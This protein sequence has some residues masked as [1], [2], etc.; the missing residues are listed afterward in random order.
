[1]I[2]SGGDWIPLDNPGWTPP[3]EFTLAVT[4]ARPT[5]PEL[6]TMSI[7]WT[8]LLAAV[9]SIKAEAEKAAQAR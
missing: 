6:A 2:A 3:V 1:M 9:D 4:G 8:N 5:V 7:Y